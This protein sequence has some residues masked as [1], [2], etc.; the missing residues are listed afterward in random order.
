MVRLKVIT[1]FATPLLEPFQFLNGAIKSGQAFCTSNGGVAFQFLNGA[2]KS[3]SIKFSDM[4]RQLFQFLN[5]AIKRIGA[6]VITQG[7]ISIS[8]PQWC[9]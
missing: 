7:S 5:G 4:I 6:V 1:L 2:I 8:I 9:D 3:V